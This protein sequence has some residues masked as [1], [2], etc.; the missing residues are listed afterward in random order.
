MYTKQSI[1]VEFVNIVEFDLA[2]YSV[3]GS[4]RHFFIIYVF[5]VGGCGSM[6]EIWIDSELFK[7]KRLVQQ[8]RMV[9]EVRALQSRKPAIFFTCTHPLA[10]EYNIAG[11]RD[12]V[13]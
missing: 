5:V 4:E 13:L 10:R 1:K 9:N 11:S 2:M 7:E 8:H 12:C 6:Y 3:C